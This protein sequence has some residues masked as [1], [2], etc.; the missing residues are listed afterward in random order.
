MIL[1]DPK[2]PADVKERII[3]LLRHMHYNIQLATR[4][5]KIC[6]GL[7]E[8][9][10]PLGE[11]VFSAIILKTL[12]LL[13]KN[14]VF[15]MSNMVGFSSST[16]KHVISIVNFPQVHLL[17]NY[18][19][20]TLNPTIRCGALRD[21]DLLLRT[22]GTQIHDYF[23]EERVKVQVIPCP[24]VVLLNSLEMCAVDYSSTA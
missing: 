9:D 3:Y 17:F 24:V 18:L 13:T 12:T 19:T 20:Q 4:A 6:T 10:I 2:R 11:E 1:T 21:L 16:Y 14:A 8:R 7:L 15:E 23:S 5:R 22:E